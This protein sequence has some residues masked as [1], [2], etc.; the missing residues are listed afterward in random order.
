MKIIDQTPFFNNE[1]GEIST[2]D[3]IKAIMKFGQGWIAEVEAQKAVITVLDSVL[4]KNYTLLRN[5]TPPG[6]EASIPFILIGPPGVY[7]IYVAHLNGTYRAKGDQWGTITGN[8]FKPIKPNLLTRTDRMARAVQIYLQRHGYAD[9][10][11]VDS[12]L[13]CADPGIHVDSLRPIV[14]VVMRDALDRFAVSVTQ[15]HPLLSPE[16]VH[17]IANRILNPP[18]SPSP[19]QSEQAEAAIPLPT[20]QPAGQEDYYIPPFSLPESPGADE[21]S[22]AW[23]ADRLGF[24]MAGTE[25]SSAPAPSAQPFIDETT[26]ETIPAPTAPAPTAPA[27]AAAPAAPRKKRRGVSR[28]QLVF[29]VVAA[30]VE[31]IFLIAFAYIVVTNFL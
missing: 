11:S 3:R 7:V 21:T 31:V 26:Q 8:T 9:L 2:I 22:P 17:N 14:R 10:T 28:G 5:V 4:D 25:G 19:Q 6:M 30:I 1:T 20:E 29:L 13:L 24:G 12:V 23:T 27:A 16:M 15:A 18:K